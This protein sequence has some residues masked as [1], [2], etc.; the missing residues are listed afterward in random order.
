MNPPT[1]LLSVKDL[2]RELGRGERYVWYMRARGFK[3]PGGRATVVE[4]RQ[5]LAR[6]P[7][8]CSTQEKVAA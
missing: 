4:A 5:W 6:H 2:A 7:K 8:P 3:M 1:Q